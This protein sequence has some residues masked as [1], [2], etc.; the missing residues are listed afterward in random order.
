MSIFFFI[1]K[2]ENKRVEQVLSVGGEGK[3]IP[4]EVGRRWG[5]R[6]GR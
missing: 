3:L 4:V 1:Y 6:L 2:S 5:K